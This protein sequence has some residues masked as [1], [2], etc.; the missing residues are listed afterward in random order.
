MEIPDRDSGKLVVDQRE[1]G[2][3]ILVRSEEDGDGSVPFVRE[4]GLA[5]KKGT[6]VSTT[7]TRLVADNF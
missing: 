1:M 6:L 3:V 5:G 7:S 2:A 4:R